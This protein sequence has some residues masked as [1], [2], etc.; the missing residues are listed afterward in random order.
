[1]IYFIFKIYFIFQ[2][3]F[4]KFNIYYLN[5]YKKRFYR[6]NQIHSIKIIL[7]GSTLS[8]KISIT[9]RMVNNIFDKT[10]NTTNGAQFIMKS[11]YMPL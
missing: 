1:M 10:I 2:I 6:A 3:I 4:D 8:E 11:Y 9:Q 7:L 5:N